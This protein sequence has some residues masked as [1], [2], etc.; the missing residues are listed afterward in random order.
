[1]PSV[2]IVGGTDNAFFSPKSNGQM[3]FYTNVAKKEIKPAA[4]H[5]VGTTPMLMQEE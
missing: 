5:S 4:T 1:V 2:T 3:P